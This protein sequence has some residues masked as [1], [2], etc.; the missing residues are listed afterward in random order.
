MKVFW[1]CNPQGDNKK[2]NE[3]GILGICRYITQENE[4]RSWAF[5]TPTSNLI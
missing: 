3:I 4:N 1:P 2:Y 5:D